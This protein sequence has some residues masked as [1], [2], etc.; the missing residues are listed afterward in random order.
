MSDLFENEWTRTL[1]ARWSGCW[2]SFSCKDNQLYYYYYY[3]IQKKYSIS[4]NQFG[5]LTFC[6]Q[7]SERE[8]LE[9]KLLIEVQVTQKIIKHFSTAEE[10]SMKGKNRNKSEIPSWHKDINAEVRVCVPLTQWLV[11][12]LFSCFHSA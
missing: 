7:Y 4:I 12:F 6:V 1:L 10:S 9:R 8:I 2:N 3:N 11:T 5:T